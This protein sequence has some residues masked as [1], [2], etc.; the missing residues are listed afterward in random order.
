MAKKPDEFDGLTFYIY[1]MALLTV[2]VGGFAAWNWKKVDKKSREIKSE[3]GKLKAMEELALD[4]EFRGWVARD[5]ETAGTNQVSRTDFQALLHNLTKQAGLTVPATTPQ[6]P[7]QVGG[8]EEMTWRLTIEDCYLDQ[9][10]P[11]LLQ[12]EE[13]WPGA[14]ISSIVKLDFDQRSQKWDAVV[15]ATIFKA[16]S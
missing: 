9:L 10:I 2:I 8:G 16:S 13:Q 11:C 7:R 14:R 15:D 1:V 12:I 4:P 3:L 6:S 5:R